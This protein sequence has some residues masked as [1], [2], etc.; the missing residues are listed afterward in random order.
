VALW[1]EQGDRVAIKQATVLPSPI[2]V[3]QHGRRLEKQTT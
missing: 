3:S 1:C 2:T